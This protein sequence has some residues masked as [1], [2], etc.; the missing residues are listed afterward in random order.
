METIQ[1]YN[2]YDVLEISAHCPQ[3]EVTTAYERAKATY[4]GENPAIY[5]VFSEDEARVLLTLVEEAYSVLGNKSLRSLYDERLNAGNC[6]KEELSYESLLVASKAQMPEPRKIGQSTERFS[7]DEKFENQIQSLEEWNGPW[8]KK[9]REYRL[10][11]LERMSE[12]TRINGYY[13]NAI[14]K[15]DNK[16]LPAAVFVRG[17]VVQI[18]KTL[19]LDSQ[20]VADSY[21]KHFKKLV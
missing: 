3:H 14:E 7:R 13:I 6:K 1:K 4:S 8:L 12:I 18:A 16:N 19:Q 2:Y 15:D 5:T 11:S 17:Y 20:K 21:M 10:I 9:V